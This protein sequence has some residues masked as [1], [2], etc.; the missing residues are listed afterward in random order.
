M[1]ALPSYDLEVVVVYGVVSV[2]IVVM[3]A[4][5]QLN[6]NSVPEKINLLQLIQQNE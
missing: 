1:V 2:V 6:C 4:C 5:L 3:K